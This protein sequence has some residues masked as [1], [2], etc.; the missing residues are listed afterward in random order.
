MT[1]ARS[2]AVPGQH[3]PGAPGPPAPGDR[4]LRADAGP[5]PAP[6]WSALRGASGLG[7]AGAG[8][9]PPARGGPPRAAP[10]PGGGPRPPG[11]GR[12]AD[13]GPLARPARRG[14]GD[15]RPGTIQGTLV[16]P[17]QLLE[18]ARR[19]RSGRIGPDPGRRDPGGRRPRPL[20]PGHLVR[21]AWGRRRI[22]RGDR[23][24]ERGPGAPAAA[25]LV[26]AAAG[27]LPHGTGRVCPGARGFRHLHRPVARASLGLFQS[28]LRTGP[29]G[30]EG[31]R[32]QR[33]HGRPGARPRVPGRPGQPR[34][35]PGGTPAIWAGAD[36]LR[37]GPRPGR[38][39][40]RLAR[41]RPRPRPGGAGAACRGRRGVPGGVRAGP[42]DRPG[43][44]PPQM[45]LRIRR[46]RPAARAGAGG[47]RRGAPPGSSTSPGALRSRDA[48]DES[49]RSRLGASDSST[50][51][52]RPTRVSSRPG[53]IGPWSCPDEA[54]GTV[55]P[56]ISTSAWTA[57]PAPA[58]P[59]TRPR[60]S[61]PGRRRPPRPL[62][63]STRRSNSWSGPGPSARG[64]G[65]TKTPT[66]PS[67][68]GIPDS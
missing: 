27:D 4:R 66:W 68:G 42:R 45:D 8:G 19:G 20:S 6:G 47:L 25:L 17:R 21:P 65:P 9:S 55:P 48:G 59:C 1:P 49:R 3:D 53:A 64:G 12:S 33:L 22:P 37:P 52:W 39:G 67:S 14:R 29:H 24:A 51:P 32:H 18:P 10:A 40:R 16:R 31:R 46:V 15:P 5:V 44:P 7:A 50:G 43:T 26:R 2:G 36:R 56:A 57:S 13:P 60:A 38:P 11:P 63:P 61:R 28:G 54:N 41:R 58:R 62:V 30:P 34:P 23:R 35:R